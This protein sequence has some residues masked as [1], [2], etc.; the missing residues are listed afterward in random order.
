MGL[1]DLFKKGSSQGKDARLEA[2]LLRICKEVADKKSHFWELND[3]KLSPTFQILKNGP[4]EE[5]IEAVAVLTHQTGKKHLWKSAKINTN[6]LGSVY[7]TISKD[8]ITALLRAKINYTEVGL[9][10]QMNLFRRYVSKAYFFPEWPVSYLVKQM[11]YHV[12]ANGLSNSLQA[13]LEDMLTWP[14]IEKES[15]SGYGS[16]M[17]KVQVRIREILKGGSGKSEA[18]SV[19]TLSEED[20]FGKA[21][22]TLTSSLVQEQ[23]SAWSNLLD[24]FIKATSSKPTKKWLTRSKELVSAL[25]AKVYKTS[26]AELLEAAS[27]LKVQTDTHTDSYRGREFTYNTHFF[28]EA[29]NSQIL[30][31]M[32]WSLVQFHD[33]ATLGLLGT[34][35]ERSFK[36]IPDVGPAMAAV[37]NASI[38]VLAN[39]KGL[40]G[41]SH[42]SRLKLKVTQN[43]TKKLIQK[44]L[45]EAS[46]KRGVSGEEIEEISI[47][48]FGLKGGQK[49]V[50]FDDYSLTLT[51][52]GVGKTTLVWT[53]PDG[54]SQKSVPAFVKQSEKWKKLL[55]KVKADAKQM[56]KYSTAQRDR[57][58]RMFILGRKWEYPHFMQY[59]IDHGLVGTVGRKLIWQLTSEGK[60]TLALYQDGGNWIDREGNLVAVTDATEVMLW[61]PIQ[62]SSDEVLAWRQHLEQLEWSQPLKQAYREVY[63][64]TDAELNTRT[65]SNRMAAHLLKQHQLNALAGIRNWKYTLLGGFD[66]GME[67]STVSIQLPTYGLRAEFWIN[68]VFIEGAMTEAGIWEFVATDQVKFVNAQEEAVEL[69]DVPALVLSEIMRD[70]DLFVGVASVGN[71]PA[72]PD[73]G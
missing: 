8:L 30:K 60:S 31:G 57:I 43:N 42:L 15:A 65:Y 9:T 22:N 19:I 27:A 52:T 49:T 50:A 36:K 46:D 71:D 10:D 37:G 58:E 23:Q 72:W 61:H 2:K 11:Q 41:V 33:S 3:F 62:A 56:Q 53:K 35:A 40:E 16:D 24:H 25:G 20:A 5:K 69:V 12:R 39:S 45:D 66:N 38:Y 63:L 4:D 73:S 14:E 28:I 51:L 17:Q 55:S 18:V 54:Q 67:D 68:E 13:Y 26:V 44:Y 47:P 6:E 34:L 70:V 29:K 64:L 32:V 59:Y 48:D 7:S 21:V 1:K